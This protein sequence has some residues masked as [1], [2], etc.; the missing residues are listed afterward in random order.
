MKRFFAS[1]EKVEWW[2]SKVRD[3][4]SNVMR[5]RVLL[6]LVKR[7]KQMLV[8]ENIPNLNLSVTTVQ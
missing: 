7:I 4:F 1:L 3:H 5:R 6:V 2:Q 8:F